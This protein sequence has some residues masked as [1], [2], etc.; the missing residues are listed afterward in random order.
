GRPSDGQW[1]DGVDAQS[2]VQDV[3][4]AE[5][6]RVPGRQRRRWVRGLASSPSRWSP[7]SGRVSCRWCGGVAASCGDAGA[8]K[9]KGGAGKDGGEWRQ[10][11]RDGAAGSPHARRQPRDACGPAHRAG[12]DVRRGPLRQMADRRGDVLARRSWSG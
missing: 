8:G 10:A 11:L 2:E 5:S 3:V 1:S 7:S 9:G 4:E 6:S 12:P